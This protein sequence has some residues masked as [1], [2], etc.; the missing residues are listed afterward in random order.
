MPQLIVD[1]MKFL[2]INQDLYHTFVYLPII[3]THHPYQ[4]YDA[5]Q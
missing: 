3:P 4:V 2:F 1:R 5:Y